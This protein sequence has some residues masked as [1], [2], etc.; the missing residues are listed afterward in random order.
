MSF[1]EHIKSHIMKRVL[2]FKLSA[3]FLC[4]SPLF[5]MPHAQLLLPLTFTFQTRLHFIREQTGP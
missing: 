5:I 3:T 1:K 4:I 2:Q